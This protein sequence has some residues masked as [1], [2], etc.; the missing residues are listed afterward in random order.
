MFIGITRN[1]ANHATVA[2]RDATHSDRDET[3]A[4]YDLSIPADQLLYWLRHEPDRRLNQ[5]AIS[6]TREYEYEPLA[7]PERAGLNEDAEVAAA[8][9][10][11]VLEIRPLG[12][13]DPWVL[14]VRVE[15]VVGPHTPEERSVPAGAE[16]ID[17]DDFERQ[18]IVPKRGIAT[19]TARADTVPAKRDFD[20]FFADLIRNRHGK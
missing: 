9:T 7:D 16:E 11:G 12:S 17:L 14:R 20:R 15:D 3:M 2:R 8:A 5:L 4:V 10:I 18:F 13:V 6:A 1:Q 19:V